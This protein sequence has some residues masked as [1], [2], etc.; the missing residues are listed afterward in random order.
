M[1]CTSTTRK[2]KAC[3][4]DALPGSKVCLVHKAHRK[5]VALVSSGGEVDAVRYREYLRSD[6]WRGKREKRKQMDGHKCVRCSS[7]EQ[8][9]V[10]H[11]SYSRLGWEPMSDLRTL[12]RAC[13]EEITGLERLLGRNRANAE[14]RSSRSREK[15]AQTRATARRKMRAD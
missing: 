12:C 10:H 9:Q 6:R 11:I 4:N 2:G 13:H 14:F 1:T 3:K 8:L 7:T 5:G 15:R